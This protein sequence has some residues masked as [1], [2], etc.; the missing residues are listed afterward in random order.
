[1]VASIQH[2]A[3]GAVVDT[4]PKFISAPYV[5]SVWSADVETKERKKFLCNATIIGDR[6]AIANASC[7]K[8]SGWPLVGIYGVTNRSQRGFVFPIFRWAWPD[9]FETSPGYSDLALL[10]APFGVSPWNQELKQKNSIPK[11][12]YPRSGKYEYI[13]WNES[14]GVQR[15]T[16]NNLITIGNI[17]L[18]K[19]KSIKS[20]IF[21][22]G[23][24]IR[25]NNINS[26][27]CNI[28]GGSPLISKSS[29]GINL[30]G[31]SVKPSTNCQSNSPLTFILLSKFSDFIERQKKQLEETF[32]KERYGESI[33]PIYESIRPPDSKEFLDSSVDG[34]GRRSVIWTSYDPESG[35]ADVWSLG[36]FVWK[37][38]RY[39]ATLI[40]RN[41]LDGCLLSK[42]GSVLLQLSKNS[43]QKVDFAAQVSDS[44]TC[45]QTGN[46][47]SYK[48]LKSQAE[49]SQIDCSVAVSP[50]GDN[51]S[52]Q[53]NEKIKNLS[54]HFDQRC[55]G[56][57]EKIWI[58]FLVRVNDEYMDTDL[59][60]FYDGWYG[61][62]KS[63]IF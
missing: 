52:A 40:F 6:F 36:F 30:V 15:L 31:I 1:M 13:T 14:G 34:D 39:Q 50:Y 32:L 22:A 42:N 25:E 9:E 62:W 43:E 20:N 44:T 58:R 41:S 46:Q 19:E 16:S 3:V 11:I 12:S 63:T 59:E 33:K 27:S 61:P 49:N 5:V 35:W 21:Y 24:Y 18:P 38:G 55:L 4:K 56:L 2:V 45:W 48:S 29:Q 54:I 26:K 57:T 37:N 51:W 7:V 53:P 60:P 8:K 23:N 17:P 47:Y 28:I 10:Y